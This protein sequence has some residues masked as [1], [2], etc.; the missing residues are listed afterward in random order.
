MRLKECLIIVSAFW[1]IAAFSAGDSFYTGN[2]LYGFCQEKSTS[3]TDYIAGIVDTLMVMNHSTKW[4]CPPN[5]MELG[6]A[7]DVTM[8]YLR[9][10]PEKRQVSAASMA[11]V[12]LIK[13]FPC[14]K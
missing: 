10:H 11:F 12:A 9:A 13:A 5:N 8:N 14:D 2:R 1:P 6:Q 7:V 3:C 4:I